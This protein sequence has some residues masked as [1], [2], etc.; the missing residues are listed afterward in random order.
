[1]NLETLCLYERILG[2]TWAALPEPIRAIHQSNTK[3]WSAQGVATVE[4]GRNLLSLLAGLLFSF[5]EAGENVPVK[6]VFETTPAGE[7]WR[8]SFAG[9]SFR[10]FQWEGSDREGRLLR[11]RFGILDFDLVLVFDGARLK[12]I[13]RRWNLLGIPLPLAFAPTGEAYEFV[14]NGRFHFHV[15]I[16]H[17]LTGLIVRY[18]GWLALSNEQRATTSDQNMALTR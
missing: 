14:E 2:E 12:L 11:E 7:I 1:M 10:S 15:E 4:R 5:P 13:P 18:R 17:P 6:V 8:R 3:C 9:R 16:A